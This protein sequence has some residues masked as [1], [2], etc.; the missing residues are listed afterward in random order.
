MFRDAFHIPPPYCLRC[1]Y[2]LKPDSCGLQCAKALEET[3]LN[4]GPETVS[5]FMGETV[6]GATLAVYPPPQGYW[7]KI[8]EICNRY[9]V[10]L[11]LDEVMSGMG[12]TGK[13]FASEHY[14]VSPDLVTLGKGLSGGSLPLSAVG[15][16]EEHYSQVVETGGFVHGGTFSHHPACA[17]AG[18]AAVQILEK[19]SLVE[20]AREK[21]EI[22]GAKLDHALSDH[23]HVGDI[24][25]LGMMW[26]VELV[27]E[28]QTLEPFDRSALV[29]EMVWEK[30][31]SDGVILYKSLGLA[32]KN[33]EGLVVAPPFVINEPE[34]DMVVSG[35]KGALNH[36]LGV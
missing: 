2:G 5:A 25:G 34:M 27:K 10:M 9:G 16:R 24:R 1:S 22:L 18:L 26:G 36:V 7:T 3:I 12:R 33:G 14:G 31:F 21:G 32:G 28:K 20:R 35:L 30:L 11:I 8:R 23:P 19:E 29:L 17:A 15:V 13:W 6:S 4:L